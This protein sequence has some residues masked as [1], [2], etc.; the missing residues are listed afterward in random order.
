MFTATAQTSYITLNN[1]VT[2][3][4]LDVDYVRISE[5]IPVRKLRYITYD[6]WNR[7][8]LET[9]LTN[10]SDSQGTPSIV[11]PT[12][13]KKFGLSP[14]PDA[15]NY[16]IQYEYWKVHTDLSAHGDTIDLD[17][18]FK[19]IIVNRADKSVCTF[20]YSYCIE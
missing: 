12:Q 16:T 11:Y 10:D 13:D 3:T 15:S 1:T 2:T 7:R 8:F 17:D 6:D 20:Q 4:N 9:D 18:R 14:V 5:N 19:D